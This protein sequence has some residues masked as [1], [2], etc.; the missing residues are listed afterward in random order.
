MAGPGKRRRSM[1]ADTDVMARLGSR[2]TRVQLRGVNDNSG[3]ADDACERAWRAAT[4][5]RRGGSEQK[6]RADTT[7]AEAPLPP[8]A[9][10]VHA[11]ARAQ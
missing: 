7:V 10:R 5:V 8:S 6:A 9:V 3:R 1:A 4:S 11:C 2:P